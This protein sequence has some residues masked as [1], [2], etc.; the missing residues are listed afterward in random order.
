MNCRLTLQA[1]QPSGKT[2]TYST[3]YANNKQKIKDIQQSAIKET[4][5]FFQNLNKQTEPQEQNNECI[6][7]PI[8]DIIHDQIDVTIHQELQGSKTT[9]QTQCSKQH[10]TSTVQRNDMLKDL[11]V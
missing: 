11:D 7:P 4:Q 1:D 9:T 2:T 8:P 3:N 5:E 10:K 6:L